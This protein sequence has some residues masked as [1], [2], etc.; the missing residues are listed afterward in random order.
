[1]AEKWRA[2]GGPPLFRSVGRLDD[3]GAIDDFLRVTHIG[4]EL[5]VSILRHVVGVESRVSAPAA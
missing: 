3:M 1:M 4:N 2:A 5:G